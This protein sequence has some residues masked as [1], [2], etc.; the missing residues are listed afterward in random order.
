MPFFLA[1]D[2]D[3]PSPWARRRGDRDRFGRPCGCS[4]WSWAFL[5]LVVCS[6]IRL[7]PGDL[8]GEVDRRS[9]YVGPRRSVSRCRQYLGPDGIDDLAL[10]CLGRSLLESLS[11]SAQGLVPLAVFKTVVPR[12]LRRGGWVRFPCVSAS[13]FR[14]LRASRESGRRCLTRVH[15]TLMAHLVATNG[16]D[17]IRGPASAEDSIPLS[18]SLAAGTVMA[19]E[20]ARR[21]DLRRRRTALNTGGRARLLGDCRRQAAAYSDLDTST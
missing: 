11:G 5:F 2:E 20:A 17:T 6:L 10:V 19:V 15:G 8:R 4:A 16:K 1:T 3:V 12:R 7:T 21:D 14:H 13:I 18:P 9:T